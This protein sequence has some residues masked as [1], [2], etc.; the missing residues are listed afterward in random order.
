MTKAEREALDTLDKLHQG[1]IG[2]H[3]IWCALKQIANGQDEVKVLA[4]Y[5]Y[6]YKGPNSQGILDGCKPAVDSSV[7][8]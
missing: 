6:F 2:A 8:E 3:W 4:E 7:K 1:K 5:G